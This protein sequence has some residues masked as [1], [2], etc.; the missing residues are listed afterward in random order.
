MSWATSAKQLIL[1]NYNIAIKK[2]DPPPFPNYASTFPEQQDNGDIRISKEE[3]K[4]LA[5]LE[6]VIEDEFFKP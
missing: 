3:E 2:K 6:R 5:M 4:A 1:G